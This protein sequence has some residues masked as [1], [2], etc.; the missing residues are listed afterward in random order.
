MVF[1]GTPAMLTDYSARA[2]TIDLEANDVGAQHR[3]QRPEDAVPGARHR[4]RGLTS[5]F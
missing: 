3:C 4:S 2:F 1:D 5:R